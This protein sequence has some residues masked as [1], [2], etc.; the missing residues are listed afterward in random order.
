MGVRGESAR[1]L[2]L[3][4]LLRGHTARGVRNSYWLVRTGA[5]IWGEKAGEGGEKGRNAKGRRKAL[6]RNGIAHPISFYGTEEEE[7]NFA[8]SKNKKVRNLL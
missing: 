7:V 8:L 3:K 6:L 1:A 4:T 2:L 5:K